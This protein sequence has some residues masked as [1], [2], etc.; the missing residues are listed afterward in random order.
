MKERETR[1]IDATKTVTGQS[2]SDE[3]HNAARYGLTLL[4]DAVIVLYALDHMRNQMEPK[5]EELV[6]IDPEATFSIQLTP[7]ELG[8]VIEKAL[9]EHNAILPPR[10]ADLFEPTDENR[11]IDG[12]RAADFLASVLMRAGGKVQGAP[13]AEA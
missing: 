6:A 9:A 12:S 10:Y 2:M 13:Q 5:A 7:E 3:F 4:Y 8:E 1:I 11:E